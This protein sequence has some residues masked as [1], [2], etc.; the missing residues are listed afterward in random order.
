MSFGRSYL[1]TLRQRVQNVTNSNQQNSKDASKPS[2]SSASKE[3]D[4]LDSLQLKD[5]SLSNKLQYIGHLTEVPAAMTY[6]SV[7]SRDSVRIMFLIAALNDLDMRMCDMG[8]AY[9]NVE[10]GEISWIPLKGY[11]HH[12]FCKSKWTAEHPFILLIFVLVRDDA[13]TTCSSGGWLFILST[14]MV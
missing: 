8:N 13:P 2:I 5:E 10:T 7:V 3:G 12:V 14:I 11:I 4:L 9:L 6:S 1:Q